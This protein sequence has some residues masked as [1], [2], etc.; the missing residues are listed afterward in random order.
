[1]TSSAQPAA[2]SSSFPTEHTTTSSAR[3]PAPAMKP[4][5][6]API[7]PA[8]DT[9]ESMKPVADVSADAAAVQ[10][11]GKASSDSV[12]PKWLGNFRVFHQ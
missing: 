4:M 7:P 9:I 2:T 11:K 3:V 6:K 12:L 8:V 5:L 10:A 1:M